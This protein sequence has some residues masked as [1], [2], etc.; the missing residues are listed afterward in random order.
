[1]LLQDLLP[2]AEASLVDQEQ[3][4]ESVHQILREKKSL[5][6]AVNVLRHDLKKVLD[7]KKLL[8]EQVCVFK[9][10]Y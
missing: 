10:T 7:E 6:D 4:P 2:S 5:Q 9:I 3:C 8:E 1:M